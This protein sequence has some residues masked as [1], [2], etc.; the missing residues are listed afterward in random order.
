MDSLITTH[1]LSIITFTPAFGALLIFFYD[2]AHVRS[3][4]AFALIISILT[5]VF[6]LHLIA[7]FDA[8]SSSFQFAVNVPWI[9]SAGISYQLGVD[10]ISV[11]LILLAALL[12]PLAILS[13]WSIQ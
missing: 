10:G 11:F 1:I 9:P 3:I 4:R 7:H 12:T 5:F 2:P 13:S 6:A 8:A